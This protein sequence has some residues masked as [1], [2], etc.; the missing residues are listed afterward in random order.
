MQKTNGQPCLWDLVNWPSQSSCEGE[1]GAGWE[2]LVQ[3]NE[4]EGVSSGGLRIWCWRWGHTWAWWPPWWR[5]WRPSSTSSSTPP[6]SPCW[7]G[8][9]TPRA[10]SLQLQV[11]IQDCSAQ[12]TATLGQGWYFSLKCAL[13]R[14]SK[15]D[16]LTTLYLSQAGLRKASRTLTRGSIGGAMLSAM[17]AIPM[18]TTGCGRLLSRGERLT[19]FT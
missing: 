7:T 12:V 9:S 17:S 16:V 4:G 3:D 18:L 14:Y 8:S 6:R 15:Y 1:Q 10:L 5:G 11:N 13:D 19:E 2:V